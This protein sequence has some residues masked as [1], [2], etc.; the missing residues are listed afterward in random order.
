MADV[1]YMCVE[2]GIAPWNASPFPRSAADW[3][4]LVRHV[5]VRRRWP[6]TETWQ[7]IATLNPEPLEGPGGMIAFEVKDSYI[8]YTK[9]RHSE[10]RR[11]NEGV[12]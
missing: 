1:P 3:W 9:S 12:P 2:V 6:A 7:H 8:L 4:R 11:A 10:Y 5:E